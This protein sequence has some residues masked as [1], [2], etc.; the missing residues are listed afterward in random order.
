MS[1]KADET[2][3]EIR[4]MLK[5]LM[6]G[7]K[8]ILEGINEIKSDQKKIQDEIKLSNFVLNSITLRNEMVN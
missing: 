6:D 8:Q 3:N 4:D 5:I 2:L 1:G 7:Q